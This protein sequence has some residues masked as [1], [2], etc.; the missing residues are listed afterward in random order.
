MDLK[1]D[2]FG[3]ARLQTAWEI[4]KDIDPMEGIEGK[5]YK[6]NSEE[7]VYKLAEIVHVVYQKLIGT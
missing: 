2:N 4:C 6:K 5:V 1:T 3:V 7:F